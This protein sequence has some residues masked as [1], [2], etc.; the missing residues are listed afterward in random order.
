MAESVPVKSLDLS[1]RTVLVTGSAK[2]IGREIAL[3][4]ARWSAR[5]IIHYRTSEP[6]ATAAAERASELGATGVT[7]VQGDVTDSDD[8]D[9]LFAAAESE[10]G[11]VDVLI[12]NVGT[13]LPTHWEEVSAE[14]WNAVVES[15]LTSTFLCSKRALPAMRDQQFGRIVNIAQSHADQGIAPQENTPYFIAKAGVLMFTQMLAAETTDDGVTVNAI[16]PFVVENSDVIPEDLPRGRPAAFK[17]VV[18]AVA[19]LLD[20]NSDYVSGLNLT[21]DGGWY[22]GS[23]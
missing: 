7:L 20:E 10:F 15:N 1:D 23:S 5:T 3:A 9:A 17:D 21:L 22:P 18:N 14:E 2:G 16:S 19:F 8:V 11:P 6:E 4:V 12:N 13:F